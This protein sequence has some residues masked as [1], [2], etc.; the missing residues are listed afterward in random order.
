MKLQELKVLAWHKQGKGP[1]FGIQFSQWP[2]EALLLVSYGC[3]SGP[4]LLLLQQVLLG[5]AL[6]IMLS[7]GWDL[8]GGGHSACKL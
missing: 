7:Q 2:H 8:W 5:P 6:G 4:I 3:R 1:T